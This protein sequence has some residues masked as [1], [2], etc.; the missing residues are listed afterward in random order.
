M[1]KFSSLALGLAAWSGLAAPAHAGD[2][3]LALAL[4]LDVSGSVD[5]AEYRLMHEGLAR[6]LLA[7][8]VVEAFLSGDPVAIYVFEWAGQVLQKSLLPGW[9]MVESEED[10]ARIAAAVARFSGSPPHI[11]PYTP[12]ALGTAL[13]HAGYVLTKG[14]DCRAST[15]DVSGDGWNNDGFGPDTAYAMPAFEGVTVNALV[16]HAGPEDR[17]QLVE[18][19]QREVLR[20]PGAFHVLAEGYDDFERAMEAKLRRELELP[21]LSGWQ[22]EGSAG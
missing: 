11:R 1:A 16:V 19:F 4:A 12:T 7:P 15:V 17:D 3:R 2:C 14:P 21:Q 22:A 13:A 10:L 8:E 5:E 6:A 18:W 9:Q 20:G